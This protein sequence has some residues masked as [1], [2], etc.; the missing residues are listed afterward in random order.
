MDIRKRQ[1]IES[2]KVWVEELRRDHD[3][4]VEFEGEHYLVIDKPFVELVA[5]TMQKAAE[6]MEAEAT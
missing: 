1:I 3:L 4:D 6:W 5:Y 2:L